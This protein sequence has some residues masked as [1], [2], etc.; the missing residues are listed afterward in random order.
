M[1]TDHT[2]NNGRQ[3]PLEVFMHKEQL[4]IS[5]VCENVN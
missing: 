3:T 4:A 5:C 1:C 2:A